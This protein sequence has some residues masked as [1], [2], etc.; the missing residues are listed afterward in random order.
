MPTPIVLHI[1]DEQD[2]LKKTYTRL[3]LKQGVVKK[4]MRLAKQLRNFDEGDFERQPA[5]RVPRGIPVWVWR[6]WMKAFPPKEQETRSEAEYAVL[7]EFI[8]EFF[9]NGI[10]RK[11]LANCDY[12]E[13]VAVLTAILARANEVVAANPTFPAPKG[14]RGR[15]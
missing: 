3:W 8:I 11:E 1:Y 4:A 13:M 7:E 5:P 15:R 14:S 9:G 2:E 12:G 6:L 10:T